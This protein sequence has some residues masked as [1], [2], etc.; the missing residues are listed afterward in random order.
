M[1]KWCSH[2]EIDPA[3]TEEEKVLCSGQLKEMFDLNAE[4]NEKWQR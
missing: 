4:F 3:R 1:G 2:E